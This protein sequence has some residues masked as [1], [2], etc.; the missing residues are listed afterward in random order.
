MAN[1]YFKENF[2]PFWNFMYEIVDRYPYGNWESEE[3]REGFKINVVGDYMNFIYNLNYLPI[4]SDSSLYKQIKFSDKLQTLVS[5]Y[6]IGGFENAIPNKETHEKFLEIL[7]DHL[8]DWLKNNLDDELK[9][10]EREYYTK[11]S[12][13]KDDNPVQQM[14]NKMARD[15][16]D[17]LLTLKNKSKL[18]TKL[19]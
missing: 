3:L 7:Q 2:R 16:E 6:K 17:V 10:A 1:N 14:A 9:S 11:V 8:S 4:N 15:K 12:F 13:S 18:N 19:G 5:R